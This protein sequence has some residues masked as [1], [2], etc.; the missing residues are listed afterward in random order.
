L[1]KNYENPDAQNDAGKGL[2]KYNFTVVP[3]DQAKMLDVMSTNH[4]IDETNIEI[5]ESKCKS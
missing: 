5:F 1:N 3:K 2:Y 4:I